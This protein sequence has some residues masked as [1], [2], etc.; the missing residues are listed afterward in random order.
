MTAF[1]AP[2]DTLPLPVK[3]EGV[4]ARWLT[5]ALR[6]RRKD[7]TVTECE[8]VDV[9]TGTSTKIRVRCRY[10]GPGAAEMPQ[11]LIVKG[12]FEDHSTNMGPMYAREVRF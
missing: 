1:I 10:T 12:G 6:D 7:L 5:A 9:I 3:P 8:I 4:T 11:T 2:P